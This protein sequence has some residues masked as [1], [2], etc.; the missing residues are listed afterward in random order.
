MSTS[1]SMEKINIC[2]ISPWRK[3]SG[4]LI[5]LKQVLAVIT[6]LARASVRI[7]LDRNSLYP[8]FHIEFGTKRKTREYILA[9]HTV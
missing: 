4:T 5:L 9:N 2:Y 3:N 8:S 7:T 6:I 1:N